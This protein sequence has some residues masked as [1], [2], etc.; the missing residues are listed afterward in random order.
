MFIDVFGPTGS[1]KSELLRTLQVY[2]GVE[3]ID[4]PRVRGFP[5]AIVTTAWQ[6]LS[7]TSRHRVGKGAGRLFSKMVSVNV[8]IAFQWEKL[9]EGRTCVVVDE[10]PLHVMASFRSATEKELEAW[11]EFVNDVMFDFLSIEV[12]RV[13]V[14]VQC[15][16]QVR[17]VRLRERDGRDGNSTI[18]GLESLE[19]EVVASVNASQR[20][21]IAL[22][23]VD[24]SEDGPLDA[25]CERI[26]NAVREVRGKVYQS[27]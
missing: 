17:A 4:K 2:S 20:P 5:L 16:N 22:V 21:H 8:G 27:T 11:R 18:V 9:R 6:W 26:M 14:A 10:C 12:P 19:N 15:A 24:N 3:V 25:A 23:E 7:L 1:G 13:V